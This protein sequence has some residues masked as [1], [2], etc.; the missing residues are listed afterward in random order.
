MV[1]SWIWNSARACVGSATAAAA[2]SVA[3]Q[4]MRVCCK[5]SPPVCVSQPH[6]GHA[7]LGEARATIGYCCPSTKLENLQ[8]GV[9]SEVRQKICQGPDLSV[10]T[11]VTNNHPSC[12]A[13][14]VAKADVR[15]RP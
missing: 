2:A 4:R 6:I 7:I 11:S 10:L 3:L 13:P 1:A 8:L 9:F 12:T 15:G 14:K 5:N